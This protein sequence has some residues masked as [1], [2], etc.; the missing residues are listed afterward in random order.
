MDTQRRTLLAALATA[1]LAVQANLAL[2]PEVG[3]ELPGARL[4]GSGRLTFLGLHV[5]DARLW[6]DDE[7]AADRFDRHALAL[8]LQYGRTLYGRLIAERSLEEM[9]RQ[10]SFSEEQG[11]RWL[12]SMKQTFPDVNKG[13]RITGVQ[14][15]GESTRIFVNGAL[16]GELRDAEFTRRFFGIWLA[17]Q[18]SEPRLR[19]SLLGPALARS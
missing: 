1:P 16:R 12:A 19:Q 2:P 10:G 7:F 15:P 13:D 11:E 5:Y 17:P 14:R 18:T 4:L 9:K 3:S 8:E 6:T